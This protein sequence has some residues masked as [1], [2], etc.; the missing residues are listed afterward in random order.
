M[1]PLVSIL[2]PAFNSDLWIAETVKS[3]LQQNWE[4]KEII[5]VDDGSTDNT[6]SIAN[7]F[8]AAN[9]LVV[10]QE[11]RGASAAR[12]K[13]LSLSQGDY[14]QWLDADDLLAP[15]KISKQMQKVNEYGNARILFSSPW[16]HFIH[17]TKKAVFSPSQLWGD[18]SP[19]EWLIRRMAGNL[20][21]Q[22]ATWLVSRELTEAAGEW[23]LRLSVGDDGE[24][25]SRVLLK[26]DTVQFVRESKV[27]YRL[28]GAYS[29]S[30]VG[31]SRSKT[32]SLFLTIKLLIRYLR[33]LEES[34]R[35]RA[36]CIKYL[37]SWVI[38]FYPERL[39]LFEEAEDI[40]TS[41]GGQLIVPSLP[42][43]YA[44]IQR[45]FGWSSAKRIQMLSQQYRLTMARSW[46][47]ALE[48][49]QD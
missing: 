5:I 34:D 43:K 42:L 14:I 40:A 13:A 20:H 33:S 11:N 36:A 26:C 32:E 9:V 35:V 37:Q 28:S 41:L 48:C 29:L 46:E 22:T 12:N 10:T 4:R 1:K 31:W 45:C 47:K 7:T 21:M 2:I 19:L 39:D 24:Y 15:D 38:Y 6:L 16:G 30:N 23:D 18:L 3:A 8:S 27:F 25:F 44:W 49:F 17:G